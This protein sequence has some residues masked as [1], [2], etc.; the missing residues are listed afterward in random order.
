MKAK[1]TVPLVSVQVK[2]TFSLKVTI[3]EVTKSKGGE[4]SYISSVLNFHIGWRMMHTKCNV[5]AFYAKLK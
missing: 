2:I 3:Y 4:W 5:L 1:Q